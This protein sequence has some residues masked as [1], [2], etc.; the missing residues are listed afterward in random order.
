ME[1]YSHLKFAMYGRR[2]VKANKTELDNKVASIES[3]KYD[4]K[5]L[6]DKHNVTVQRAFLETE[7][8]SEAEVRPE[9][10]KMMAYIAEGKANAILCSKIDRLSRNPIDS[11]R[12]ETFIQKGKIKLVLATDRIWKPDD[13]VIARVLEAAAAN[14]YIIDLRKHIKRGQNEALR[15]GF[16]PGIAP[17]G[18]KN[19]KYREKGTEEEIL[20]DE[21][22]ARILRM[23][24]DKVLSG[25]YTP[26]QV[27]KIAT[28]EWG[29]RSRKTRRYPN[30]R[31]LSKASWYN[32]LSNPFYYGEFQYPY[33]KD[34]PTE[35][36]HKGKHKPLIKRA[37]FDE[38]QRILGKAAPRPKVHTHAY[39]GLMRCGECGARITCE[40][41]TKKQ[42]NGNVH[43]YIYYRCTGQVDPDCT[44]KCTRQDVLEEQIIEYLASI[45][46]SPA[47][48]DWAIGEL[49]KEYDR[50]RDDKT[51]VLYAQHREYAKAKT[52]L[53]QLFQMRLA[54]EISSDKYQE[55]KVRLE[56]EERRLAGQLETIDARVKK[57]IYDAERLLTFSERAVEEFKG[58]SLEKKRGILASLGTEHPL[59][60]RKL[61]IKTESPL[62]VMQEV[63]SEID[64]GGDSLEPAVFLAA[65]GP[66][67]KM[68]PSCLTLWRWRESNPR[69]KVVPTGCGYQDSR[70][71]MP[72]GG[73]P[74]RTVRGTLQGVSRRWNVNRMPKAR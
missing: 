19:S 57:W 24:F 50:E 65:Y 5:E 62:Q 4:T 56:T 55:E 14:Q 66:N 35:N 22:N 63:V 74:T 17:I 12:I 51:T 34:N 68:L 30:G 20:V 42:K 16:R 13:Y 72:Y 70:F 54:G 59:L 49:R 11:A 39:V 23:M 32:I 37:E 18:Y 31:P 8:A 43:H 15:R 60:D 41:K 27:L 69:P 25:Q 48:H 2:S 29:F 1:D 71:V 46:I 61:T 45:Q 44:Q 40:N 3:Q 52:M 28:D 10:E 33:D 26:F 58:A 53:E 36:W 7:S 47:F 64:R 73:E 9:F 21:D 38:I 6:G 67:G